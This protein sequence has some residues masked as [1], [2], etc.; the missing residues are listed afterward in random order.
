M[1]QTCI[2]QKIGNNL[3]D[4]NK[5]FYEIIIDS[6]YRSRNRGN[7]RT[8]YQHLQK[9]MKPLLKLRDLIRKVW[10][11]PNSLFDCRPRR[12]AENSNFHAT[13]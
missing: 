9:L 1:R 4:L 6:H 3:S 8:F 11:S 10:S 2:Y 7:H 13:E 12:S 5:T